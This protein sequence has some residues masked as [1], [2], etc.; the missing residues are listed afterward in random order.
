MNFSKYLI[1]FGLIISFG[2]A[3]GMFLPNPPMTAPGLC[4]VSF[5]T[6]VALFQLC[7]T[8]HNPVI[9]HI[10]ATS[11]GTG[12]MVSLLAK[13]TYPFEHLM[14]CGLLGAASFDF[15]MQS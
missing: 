7:R 8:P 5:V 9:L 14:A 3:K 12:T 10:L 11:I 1:I 4:T 15:L 6:V 13:S 2:N